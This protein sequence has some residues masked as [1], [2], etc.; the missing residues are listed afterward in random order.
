MKTVIPLLFALCFGWCLWSC[1]PVQKI[2]EI[3]E[4]HF[5]KYAYE[6][7][8][9]ALY[10]AYIKKSVLT[11]S[12]IDGDGD[13]G[14]KSRYDSISKIHYTWYKKLSDGLYEA[15]QFPMTGAVTDSI[16]IPYGSVMNKEEA[17]NKTLKGTIEMVISTPEKPKDI[18]LMR[19]KFYIFDRAGNRSNVE[20]TPD[21]SIQHPP[22]ELL[23]Q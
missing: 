16:A 1:E 5:K 15:Y 2:S 9:D 10:D 6:D 8:W 12:F 19:I 13:I 22:E 14:V 7:R 11:F 21:F 4:I 20:Y 23:P 3:P 17:H 18:D